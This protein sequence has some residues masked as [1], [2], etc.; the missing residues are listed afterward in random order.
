MSGR[1]I[2]A[3]VLAVILLGAVCAGIHVRMSF[4][5]LTGRDDYLQ[6]VRVAELPESI[7]ENLSAT[8]YPALKEAGYVLCVTPAEPERVLWKNTIVQ[9]VLVENVFRGEGIAPGDA[10]YLTSLSDQ[11]RLFSYGRTA[12]DFPFRIRDCGFVHPMRMGESYLCFLESGI[13]YPYGLELD[14]P[15]FCFPQTIV[16]P[17]FSLSDHEN[18]AVE[19]PESA[20]STYV[21]YVLV[22]DNEFFGTTEKALQLLEELKRTALSDF[23]G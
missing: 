1:K 20:V 5:N 4:T 10:L 21:D 22:Q 14:A 9:K 3:A 11:T 18:T 8:V 15:L 16:K 6:T 7:S 17:Q 2:A 13:E 19:I 12:L 23:Y